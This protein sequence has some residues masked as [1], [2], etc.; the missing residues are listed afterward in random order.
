[1]VGNGRMG[2]LGARIPQGNLK[3]QRRQTPVPGVFFQ[4]GISYLPQGHSSSSSSSIQS[5][6]NP[7]SLTL[8]VSQIRVTVIGNEIP[9]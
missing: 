4:V 9:T 6:G 2:G 7:I 8:S 3:L 5:P 1:M